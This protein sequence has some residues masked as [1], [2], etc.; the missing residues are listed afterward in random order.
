[1]LCD[2]MGLGKTIVSLAL[3]MAN[4]PP[5]SD[6]QQRLLGVESSSKNKDVIIEEVQE[7][8]E[9]EETKMDI[10]DDDEE[11]EGPLISKS[12]AKMHRAKF[13][14]LKK[15]LKR[16]HEKQ[17]GIL[18]AISQRVESKMSGGGMSASNMLDTY[19]KGIK[20]EKVFPGY[21]SQKWQGV[22]RDRIPKSRRGVKNPKYVSLSL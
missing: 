12:E 8:E 14:L 19:M 1:M 18:A 15:S 22:V 4:P 6:F 11:A 20:V 2:E 16:D 13:K 10:V 3:I 21:G 7:E 17:K 5:G 9:E